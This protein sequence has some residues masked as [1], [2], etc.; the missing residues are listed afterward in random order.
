MIV[1]EFAMHS[2]VTVFVT[3]QLLYIDPPISP[4]NSS[5]NSEKDTIGEMSLQNL[6]QLISRHSTYFE[7]HT[8]KQSPQMSEVHSL[9]CKLRCLI[10]AAQPSINTPC[11]SQ[12]SKLPQGI[13]DQYVQRPMLHNR[14]ILQVI[15]QVYTRRCPL[16]V[17]N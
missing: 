8:Q 11:S 16:A 15:S 9:T 12:K 2:A 6:P 4:T 3:T 10:L 13:K 17:H 1:L 5:F 7:V 14:G